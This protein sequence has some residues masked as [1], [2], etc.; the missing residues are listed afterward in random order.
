M[1]VKKVQRP[2]RAGAVKPVTDSV[3]D[4]DT[5]EDDEQEETDSEEEFGEDEFGELEVATKR[6]VAPRVQGITKF[7]FGSVEEMSIVTFFSKN[8]EQELCTVDSTN[9]DEEKIVVTVLP[10]PWATE[11]A[12]D[13]YD[14]LE[15][16]AIDP[17]T[18]TP[19]TDGWVAVI[20]AS[21]N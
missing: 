4:N 7:L 20:E 3:V 19:E 1:A 16:D 6:L 2:A 21:F 9:I 15:V 14:S 12:I 5:I 13:I 10:H 8:P 17:N 11:L 18:I